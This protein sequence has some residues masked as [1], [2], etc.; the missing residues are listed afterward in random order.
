MKLESVKQQLDELRE[1]FASLFEQLDSRQRKL[2]VLGLALSVVLLFF[3]GL[4]SVSYMGESKQEQAQLYRDQIRQIGSLQVSY[5]AARAAKQQLGKQ[6][7]S[8]TVS[9]FSFLPAV[10]KQLSLNLSDLDEK[11]QNIPESNLVQRSVS[12]TLKKLS[13]DKLTSFLRAVE[14]SGPTKLIKVIRLKVNRR[15][16]EDLD[17][18]LTIATWNSL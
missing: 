15:L 8:S 6:L 7:R 5:K 4:Y 1:R 3:G 13:I 17:A 14:D 11:T 10:A 2:F 12:I 18:Q 9:L 16:D